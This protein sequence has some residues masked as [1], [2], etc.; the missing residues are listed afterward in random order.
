MSFSEESL[1]TQ[2]ETP[3]ER[4]LAAVIEIIER[5]G[6]DKATTRSIAAAAGVNV[7]AINYYFQ[8]KEALLEAALSSSWDHALGHVREFIAEGADR[9]ARASLKGLATFLV[10]GGFRFPAVT[11]A[12]I[13]ASDG[14]PRARTAATIV[15]LERETAAL[16][17][18]RYGVESDRLL[19]DSVE[20]FF[21]ALFL[22]PLLPDI[23]PSLADAEARRKYAEGRAEDLAAALERRRADA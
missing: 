12:T 14:S 23:F 11:R 9:D 17:A 21:A 18:S 13:F 8:S 5:E 19:A 15:Q 16:L 7:A 20:A 4:I 22:P 3:R 10:E 6:P 1:D 2:P